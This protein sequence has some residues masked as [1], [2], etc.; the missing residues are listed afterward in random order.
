MTRR[1]LHSIQVQAPLPSPPPPSSPPPHCKST[2]H[3]LCLSGQGS[4]L[5]HR[6]PATPLSPEVCPGAAGQARAPG[7]THSPWLDRSSRVIR[8]PL[9]RSHQLLWKRDCP[10]VPLYTGRDLRAVT[11]SLHLPDKASLRSL[12][13][14]LPSSIPSMPQQVWNT[15]S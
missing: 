15:V 6:T 7:H 14:T 4:V 1:Y 2:H 12:T 3:L 9:V 10:T 5:D 8:L 11:Q 13:P